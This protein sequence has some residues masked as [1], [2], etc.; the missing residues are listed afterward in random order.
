MCLICVS[1]LCLTS[2][3]AP[4][5]QPSATK[6]VRSPWGPKLF[7]LQQPTF[8]Y[9]LNQLRLEYHCDEW[10]CI[11]LQCPPVVEYIDL[12]APKHHELMWDTHHY[13]CQYFNMAAFMW[14]VHVAPVVVDGTKPDEESHQDSEISMISPTSLKPNLVVGVSSN[15]GLR[16]H[17]QEMDGWWLK[18]PRICN[19]QAVAPRN[20]PPV[21]V[22]FESLRSCITSTVI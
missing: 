9:Q 4:V 6:Q 7:T 12:A 1:R 5:W 10:K 11:H 13:D 21:G 18:L 2:I 14:G 15:S 20:S 19:R 22:P 16:D 17:Q 3:C 8:T